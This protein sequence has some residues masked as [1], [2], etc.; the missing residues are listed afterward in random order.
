VHYIRK[1]VV[2]NSLK[3]GGLDF[4]DF[5]T[6][7]NTLKINWLK[8]CLNKPSLW[9]FIILFLTNLEVFLFY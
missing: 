3:N 2:V 9:N 7:N 5:S 6:L 8:F 4:L 1:S